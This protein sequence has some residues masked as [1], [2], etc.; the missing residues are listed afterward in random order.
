MDR[1][2]VVVVDVVVDVEHRVPNGLGALPLLV[3][4]MLLLRLPLLSPFPPPPPTSDRARAHIHLKRLC[5]VAAA[6]NCRGA[7]WRPKRE[8]RVREGE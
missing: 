8:K 4:G 6:D 3:R 1:P 5:F 7:E 2:A